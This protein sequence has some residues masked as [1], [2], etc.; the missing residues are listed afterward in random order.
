MIDPHRPAVRL[1]RVFQAPREEVFRAFVD[2]EAVRAWW[3]PRGWMTPY[4][5]M[6]VRVGGSYRFGM[7][8]EGGGEMMFVTGE[9]REV[10]PPARLVFTY[11]WQ[12]GGTGERWR[13]HGLIGLEMVVTLEFHEVGHSTEVHLCHEGFPTAEGCELHYH[14]WSSNLDCLEDYLPRC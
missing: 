10:Q 7:C 1:V 11:I 3:A 12:P 9:Y 13:E 2:P 6:D 8:E 4:A 5:A 14:G